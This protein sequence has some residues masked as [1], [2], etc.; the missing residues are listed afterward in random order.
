V[1][2]NLLD[3]AI[4]YTPGGTRILV[5]VAAEGGR[6]FA[7]VHDQGAGI[8]PTEQ[9]RIFEKFYRLDPDQTS[10]VSGTGLG[11]YISR[12]LIERMGGELTVSSR[13]GEGSTFAVALPA[14]RS[15]QLAADSSRNPTAT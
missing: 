3:N 11:L 4:K 5:D 8:P 7:R 12:E 13:E 14:A 9:A 1:L 2:V 6:V 10:G 15:A